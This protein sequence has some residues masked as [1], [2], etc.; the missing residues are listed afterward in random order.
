MLRNIGKLVAVTAI[1][2]PVA[3]HVADAG[4]EAL[5]GAG[6]VGGNGGSGANANGG[7]GTSNGTPGC[8][9]GTNSAPDG[10]FYIP[11]TSQECNPGDADREKAEV[12]ANWEN[13][14]KAITVQLSTADLLDRL[15]TFRE[16]LSTQ[17]QQQLDQALPR[18][19]NGGIAQCADV[20]TSR[21]SCEN[22]AYMRALRSTGLLPVFVSTI[23][24]RP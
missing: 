21:A 3:L 24:P 13:C 4:S 7:K 23:C 22:G 8:G 12:N 14:L 2:L 5:T 10:R 16:H 9:G 20:D 11:G 1:L 18:S 6:G 17:D 19:S 15:D